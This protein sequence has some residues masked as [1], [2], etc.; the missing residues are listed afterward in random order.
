MFTE[1]NSSTLDQN[2]ETRTMT[3]FDHELDIRGLNLPA[4]DLAGEKVSECHWQ[5]AKLCE[6]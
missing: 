1:P 4:A 2:H 5:P 6:S 3:Q